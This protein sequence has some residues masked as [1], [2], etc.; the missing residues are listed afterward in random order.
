[1]TRQ[2]DSLAQCVSVA[3]D[4]AR[5]PIFRKIAAVAAGEALLGVGGTSG[6]ARGL[7]EEAWCGAFGTEPDEDILARTVRTWMY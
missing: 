4:P 6:I 3:T 5:V 2:V 1:M 7:L